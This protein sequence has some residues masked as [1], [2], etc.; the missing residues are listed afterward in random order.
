MGSVADQVLAAAARGDRLAF[1]AAAAR[2]GELGEAQRLVREDG[3]LRMVDRAVLQEIPVAAVQTAT[4]AD[5]DEEAGDGTLLHGHFAVFDEWTEIDSYFEG[6]FMERLAPG[7]FRKTFRENR[8]AIKVLF[9]HGMDPQIGDK[10]L[11]PIDDLREDETG[12]YYEVPLL[13]A[14]Y[15]RDDILPGLRAGLYGASFRFQV[16]R[17]EFETEPDPSDANPSGLPER[18]IKELRLFEFGPVTFPAYQSATAGVRAVLR[19]D[20]TDFADATPPAEDAATTE[21]HHSREPAVAGARSHLVL[22]RRGSRTITLNDRK[23]GPSWL[24]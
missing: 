2:F 21:P 6:H 3:V 16:M 14:P 8:D 5:D 10:P 18:T 24:L 15:V 20:E 11:G 9:Q 13:D 19:V 23:E 4:R 7:A 12:A 22:G 1:A 17:E